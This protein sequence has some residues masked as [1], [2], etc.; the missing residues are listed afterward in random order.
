M[1]KIALL[2]YLLTISLPT[3]S[4]DRGYINTKQFSQMKN[5][6]F[7]LAL[8]Y[9]IATNESFIHLEEHHIKTEKKET[10]SDIK[11]KNSNTNQNHLSK[12]NQ[13]N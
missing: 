7:Q 13:R 8:I 4:M 9:Q 11:F 10:S 12:N 3:H 1:K 5:S 2:I 6:F